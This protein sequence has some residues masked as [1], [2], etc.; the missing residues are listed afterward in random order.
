MEIDYLA[1]ISFVIIT[2]FTPGPNNISS[3]SMGILYGYNASLRYLLGIISGFVLIM[4]LSGGISTAL[5]FAIPAIESVLHYVALPTSS[6]WHTT[7]SKQ[8]TA[9]T[10][11]TK[12]CSA[13]PMASSCNCSTPK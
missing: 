13:S 12:N 8:V 7:P 1:F 2:T 3:A 9:L 10:K 11:I 6:G 5:L 4:L